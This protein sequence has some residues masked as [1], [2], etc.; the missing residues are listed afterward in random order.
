MKQ[1]RDLGHFTVGS[2]CLT[3]KRMTISRLK[4]M[5]TQ[6]WGMKIFCQNTTLLH[7]WFCQWNMNYG[8]LKCKTFLTAYLL[9]TKKKKKAN[10]WD[11]D[12]KNLVC[13]IMPENLKKTPNPFCHLSNVDAALP[14]AAQ[15]ASNLSLPNDVKHKEKYWPGFILRSFESEGVGKCWPVDNVN[16]GVGAWNVWGRDPA[17]K[18]VLTPPQLLA[19]SPTRTPNEALTQVPLPFACSSFPFQLSQ[20]SVKDARSTALILMQQRLRTGPLLLSPRRGGSWKQK[21]K[22]SCAGVSGMVKQ[23]QIS[24]ACCWDH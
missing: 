16:T 18:H 5:T 7:A 4:E 21:K 23:R 15:R 1:T 13:I 20:N 3:A 12:W 8:A 17:R 6:A 24:P 14:V 9:I 11:T 10:V 22:D 19:V 2:L